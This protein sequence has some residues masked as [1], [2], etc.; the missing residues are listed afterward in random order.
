MSDQPLKPSTIVQAMLRNNPG[1]TELQICSSQVVACY[2]TVKK[3][4][5]NSFFNQNA[6]II[7]INHSGYAIMKVYSGE[8][9]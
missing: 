3:V 2:K 7:S 1:K 8:M 4:L 9:F 5:S 6:L